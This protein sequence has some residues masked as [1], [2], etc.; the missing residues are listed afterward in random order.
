MLFYYNGDNTDRLYNMAV[1]SDKN[2]ILSGILALISTWFYLLGLIPVYYAFSKTKPIVRNL[3][4]GL[5]AGILTAYGV[6]HGAF[7]AIATT[8][9]V[10]MQNNLDIKKN[11]ELA[12]ESNNAI[13]LLVYPV[14][15]ILSVLFIY[16]V[17]KKNTYYPKW[18]VLFFPLLLFLFN[19][20]IYNSLSGKWQVIIGGGYLNIILIVFFTASAVALWNIL[21]NINNK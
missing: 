15:A 4:V 21:K 17:W 3:V 7:V 11:A 14:F 9:K 16:H 12:L 2:I 8:A 19:G 5:F 18:M 1:A 20:I 6:I 10:A 13:R